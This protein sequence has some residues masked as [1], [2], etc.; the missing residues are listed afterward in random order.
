M[1]CSWPP[2]GPSRGEA[3]HAAEHEEHHRHHHHDVGAQQDV[4]A[5]LLGVGAVAALLSTA[6]EEMIGEW[7]KENTITR[8]GQPQGLDEV[9]IEGLTQ[10]RG[11]GDDGTVPVQGSGRAPGPSE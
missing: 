5:L 8:D 1:F 9:A 6:K 3:Q 2:P 7:L 10:R 4:A 11:F